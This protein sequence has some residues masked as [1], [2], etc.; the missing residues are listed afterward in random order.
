[1][2]S[3]HFSV[4][5]TTLQIHLQCTYA[6]HMR[7]PI[8]KRLVA[9]LTTRDKPYEVR[10]EKVKGF[11]LRVQPSRKSTYYCGYDRGKQFKIGSTEVLNPYQAR[12]L[13]LDIL[14]G[15]RHDIEPQKKNTEKPEVLT[16][17]EFLEREYKPWAVTNLKWG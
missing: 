8:N 12:D 5:G 14:S 10:D 4:Y 11:L 16:L 17:N 15:Y 2:R 9:S 1:M 13:T 3:Y 7:R 6:V